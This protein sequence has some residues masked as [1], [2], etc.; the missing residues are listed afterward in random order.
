MKDIVLEC[1]HC[2]QIFIVA[3]NELNCR[4]FRHAKH[5]SHGDISPHASKEELEKLKND[6]L[7]LGCGGPFKIIGPDTNDNY[8]AVICD[9]L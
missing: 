4:I 9:Y 5:V 1:P 6:G 3:L 8:S 2:K 7:L